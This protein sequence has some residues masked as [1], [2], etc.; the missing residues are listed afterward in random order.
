MICDVHA[1][2]DLYSDA[3][4]E[5]VLERAHAAGVTDIVANS[6]ERTTYEKTAALAKRYEG[7]VRIRLAAGLYPI[8]G[9]E[10]DVRA[11]VLT[12]VEL[13]PER[14]LAFIEANAAEIVA[15][16][17]VG[18]DFTD[19]DDAQRARDIAILERVLELAQRLAKP[20]IVHSRRAERET[21]EILEAHPA[22]P[23][24]LH[25]F[26]GKLA[27]AK[28]ALERNATFFSIPVIV[29]H[30]EQFQR[31]VEQVPERRLLT[32][33]DA[34]FLPPRDAQRSEPAH[35]ARSIATI[36]RLRGLD[37]H[38][39]ENILYENARRLFGF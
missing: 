20:V 25:C 30:A 38:E 35:L 36:A 32:E 5:G 4:I 10:A 23:A 15:I 12:D 16:G 22:V 39:A 11:G 24:V 8:A 26:S 33:T 27:L 21:I 31:L 37:E 29:E 18:L 1:H 19:A 3:E 34:P 28:R 9:L 14:T 13:E 2:L 17:E 6:L 7:P